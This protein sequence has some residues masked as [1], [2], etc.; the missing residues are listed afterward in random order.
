MDEYIKKKVN[1]S[2][3]SRSILEKKFASEEELRKKR[4]KRGEDDGEA[5]IQKDPNEIESLYEQLAEK[6]RLAEEEFLNKN[7]FSNLVHNL[8]AGS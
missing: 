6:K 3:K 8:D 5:E 7:K 4:I 1:P 2:T